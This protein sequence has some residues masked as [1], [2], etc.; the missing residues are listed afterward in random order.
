VLFIA[1]VKGMK[2]PKRKIHVHGRDKVELACREC[3]CCKD[4]PVDSIKHLGKTITVKCQCGNTFEVV[5]E[6]RKAY[7]KKTQLAGTCRKSFERSTTD[8]IIHDISKTGIG[9]SLV[10]DRSLLQNMDS[11]MLQ[12]GDA[13]HVE[14]KLDN[15]RQACISADVVVKTIEDGKI[16]A[17][18]HRPDEH[19]NKMIG[20]YLL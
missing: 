20:F 8:I 2:T 14:F 12:V 13:L 9:F 5:F 6:A 17:V 15:K 10:P 18:F 11:P 16:G 19:T 1:K 4:I 3:F 7:R